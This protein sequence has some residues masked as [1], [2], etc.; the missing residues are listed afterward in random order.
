VTARASVE[1]LLLAGTESLP[2]SGA[3]PACC[4][5]ML[6]GDEWPTAIA[7]VVR[8]VRLE[9]PDRLRSRLKLQWPEANCPRTSIALAG[10]FELFPED[11]I[12]PH[13]LQPHYMTFVAATRQS[14]PLRRI[15]TF[16]LAVGPACTFSLWHRRQGSHVPYRSLI[17]LRA[18]SSPLIWVNRFAREEPFVQWRRQP[19]CDGT[20]RMMREYPVRICEGL[21]VKFPGPTRHLRQFSD[22]RVTSALPPKHEIA[23]R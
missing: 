20:S 14:A 1:N 8:K 2:A 10:L 12:Q 9:V 22:V 17:E 11:V 13:S 18:G 4:M 3:T 21:G 16:G 19:S 15:G 5:A 23:P 6:I 7:E